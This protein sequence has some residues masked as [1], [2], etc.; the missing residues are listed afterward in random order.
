MS[1]LLPHL[2]TAL[3]HLGGYVFFYF[4]GY[5]AVSILRDC[6]YC[7]RAGASGANCRE[8]TSEIG[9]ACFE[10]LLSLR[11]L[12]LTAIIGWWLLAGQ[13]PMGLQCVG[14]V[15]LVFTTLAADPQMDVL[16]FISAPFSYLA[17]NAMWIGGL[18]AFAWQVSGGKWVPTLIYGALVG[19]IR[20]V[21]V[22]RVIRGF[23]ELRNSS[24][25]PDKK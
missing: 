21:R 14:L 12:A 10:L 18:T 20:V 23:A 15:A 25:S 1:H 2:L 19:L 13:L 7:M 22:V 17:F 3:R 16:M 11:G 8:V 5:L 6:Y 24:K 9:K 4:T